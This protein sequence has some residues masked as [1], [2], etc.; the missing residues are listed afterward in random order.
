[1]SAAPAIGM[2]ADFLSPE[3]CDWLIVQ[4]RERLARAKVFDRQTGAAVVNQARTNSA[5]EFLLD[6]ADI[7][8]LLVQTRIAAFAGAPF[9]LLEPANI[10][11]YEVGQSFEPHHDWFN[12]E[13]PGEAA[14]MRARG[15]RVLTFLV[16]LNDGF[17]GGETDFP[18][19]G[20]RFKGQRG[21]ALYFHNTDASGAPARRTRHAGL[22]PTSGEKWILSQWVRAAPRVT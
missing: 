19:A 3:I 11:H 21:E 17:E 14:E 4:G 8:L 12:V 7:V 20:L 5:A 1:M 22:A 9:Y 16:Y 10:L 18:E 13:E 2:I 15:Q 6:D